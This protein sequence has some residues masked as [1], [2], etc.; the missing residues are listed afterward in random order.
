MSWSWR[1]TKVR[2]IDVR[3]HATFFLAL[4]W[5][6][7]IWGGGRLSGWVYGAFLTLVLFAVVL[8]HEF[9]HAIAAQRYG[10][11]VQDIL[12]LPIGGLARLNR[13]PD[14]PSQELVVALAGPAVNVIMALALAPFL[15]LGMAAGARAGHGFTLPALTQPGILNLV[16]FL[17]VINISLLVFNMIPA[18]PMDGGRVLRALLALKL[19]YPRATAIAAN[20]GRMCAIAFGVFGILSGNL[21]LALIAMF[22]FFGAGAELQQVVQK[23]SLRGLTVSEVVDS[24]APVFPASLPAFTAF[25]RLVRSPYPMVAVVDDAGG[26]M[27]V[28]TRQGMQSRWAMGLRGTIESFV[29]MA[30]PVHVECDAPLARAREQMAEARSP[31]A[32]V[33]CGNSFEG[34]LD[35]ETI[36]R[37]IAMRQMGWSGKPGPAAPGGWRA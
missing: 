1:I 37:I 9:G 28:V 6:A 34:L 26:F 11:K 8:A 30:P 14:K 35:L 19:P 32:A 10:V 22:V 31:V 27:G 24:H 15:V 3:V 17:V 18:F 23:E 25:E 12:L 4:L 2:G 36:S 5:G 7:F 29:E 16:A 21:A 13:M 33:Y 20:V